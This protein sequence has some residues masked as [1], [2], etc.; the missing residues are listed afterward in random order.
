M[1]GH[2][3]SF[4][5]S[6]ELIKSHWAA[7]SIYAPMIFSIIARFGYNLIRKQKLKSIVRI[8]IY[9]YNAFLVAGC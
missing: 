8:P 2:I 4:A 6:L 7:Y 9:G 1:E 3:M 5:T